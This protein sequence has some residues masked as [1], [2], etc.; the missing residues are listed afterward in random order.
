VC[1]MVRKGTDDTEVV[2]SG[3]HIAPFHAFKVIVCPVIS[4]QLVHM[5]LQWAA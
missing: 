5:S 4:R 1:V 2:V 3:P